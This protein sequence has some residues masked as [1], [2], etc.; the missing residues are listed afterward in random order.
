MLNTLRSFVLLLAFSITLTSLVRAQGMCSLFPSPPSTPVHLSTYW[1]G[2]VMYQYQVQVPLLAP[3]VPMPTWW[4]PTDCRLL[5]GGFDGTYYVYSFT[6]S[7][8]GAGVATIQWNQPAWVSAA[9][10]INQ[11]IK[12]LP[13]G[14]AFFAQPQAGGCGGPTCTPTSGAAIVP[15]LITSQPTSLSTPS[16]VPVTFQ[17]SA[18]QLTG[19]P[20][21]TYQWQTFHTPTNTWIP[22]GG[23]TTS[24]LSTAVPGR[25]RVAIY[26]DPPSNYTWEY[27]SQVT[28]TIAPKPYCFGDGSGATC[29]CGAG[30]AGP[31][32]GGCMNSNGG[33]GRLLAVGNTQVSSDS[34]TFT[35][36]GID[37]AATAMLFQGTTSQAA[38]QG[39]AFGDGLLCV[40][41]T[42]VRMIIRS[43]TA[44]SVSF[45]NA[46]ADPSLSSIGMVPATGATRY[47][48]VWYRDSANFCSGA[49]YNLTN[50]IEL[51]WQP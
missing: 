39:S 1:N 11:P 25:Y 26:F 19:G 41:G 10:D 20:T 30:Q 34:V 24:S 17:V 45:G 36:S 46:I 22:V 40:N 15:S 28:L 2:R 16:G 8:F 9:C 21:P 7:D 23:A 29:P 4:N 32:G 31:V 5:I 14:T 48:Q 38:G 49:A 6:A 3:P 18:V 37:G 33:G 12:K 42:I 43:A 47:Y 44:G 35:A 27:S 13:P 51:A 50:G